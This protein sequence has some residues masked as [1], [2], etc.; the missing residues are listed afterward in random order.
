MIILTK[1]GSRASGYIETSGSVISLDHEYRTNTIFFSNKLIRADGRSENSIQAVNPSVS[2]M[3]KRVVM[4]GNVDMIFRRYVL[5]VFGKCMG[6]P[7]RRHIFIGQKSVKTF[8]FASKT[9]YA[10]TIFQYFLS[11]RWLMIK[12]KTVVGFP[13]SEKSPTPLVMSFGTFAAVF[14]TPKIEDIVASKVLLYVQS[15]SCQFGTW[16]VKVSQVEGCRYLRW[17]ALGCRPR[18]CGRLNGTIKIT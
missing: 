15:C 10:W 6:Y 7:P 5:Q 8:V 12:I 1:L 11:E 17:N 3:K 14:L 9:A 18:I 4:N 2:R 13:G 16:S